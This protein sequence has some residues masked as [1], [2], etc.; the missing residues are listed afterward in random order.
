MVV[1]SRF[2]LTVVALIVLLPVCARCADFQGAESI[3]KKL[4][5][6]ESGAEQKKADPLD[7]LEAKLQSYRK[8]VTDLTPEEAASQWL[9]LLD[10]LTALPQ[11]SLFR[12]SQFT[13]SGVG[14]DALFSALPP[15]SAWD[16]LAQ[17]LEERAAKGPA[18]AEATFRLLA[19]LLKGDASAR[20]KA[21]AALRVATVNSKRPDFWG[22]QMDTTVDLLV[23]TLAELDDTGDLLAAFTQRLVAA[24]KQSKKQS[25]MSYGRSGRFVVPDIVKAA[26]REKAAPLLLRAILLPG[27]QIEIQ[28][29]ATHTL[30][31]ELALKNV[32]K[33]TSPKWELI[34]TIEDAPL[35]EAMA[36]RFPKRENGSDPSDA[37][38]VYLLSLIASGKTKEASAFITR[39]GADLRLGGLLFGHHGVGRLIGGTVGKQLAAFLHEVLLKNPSALFWDEYI[40]FSARS[41]QSAEALALLK[42]S[43]ERPD[44][45][46]EARVA[47]VKNFAKALLA[48]DQVD[49][50]VRVL[51]ET[52][53]IGAQGVKATNAD[54]EQ[55]YAK[56]G[57][58]L[59]PEA[60]R[61]I[62]RDVYSDER[63]I[64]SAL[65]LARIGQL[66]GRPEL[67]EEGITAA[68]KSFEQV[69]NEWGRESEVQSLADLLIA[70]NRGPEAEA[71]L[72]NELLRGNRDRSRLVATP[73]GRA[74]LLQKLAELYHI[75][76]RHAD[77]LKLLD[78]ATDWGAA[79][80]IELNDSYRSG[81]P[82]MHIAASA[83]AAQGRN[84]EAHK[85]TR[86]QLEKHPG[87]DRG[88]ALLLK[89]GG[90]QVDAELDELAK[91]DR[92]EE[93]PLI[94]KAQRL[95]QAGQLEDA[96]K[97][98]R[99]AIAIDPSDGEQGKGDRMRAYAVLGDILEKKGDAAQA[100]VM[101]G[102][103]AAI[104]LSED[105]DDW[106]T[107]GLLSR[108]VKKYEE[109]LGLFA[110]AYCIQSR[111]ALRYSELGDFARAEQYYRRAYE[112]MPESFGRVESHC[113]GCEGAFQG[114]RA[115]GIAETVFTRLAEK[116]PE[117]P[118]VHYLLGYLRSEQGRSEEAAASYRKAVALDPDYLNAWLKLSSLR[119]EITMP[120][121]ES[122]AIAFAILRLDPSG[123][124]GSTE[125][126][127]VH[128]LRR[129]WDTIL[130]VEKDQPPL[131]VEPIFP[132]RAN[133]AEIDRKRKQQ[134][135][136]EMFPIGLYRPREQN[137]R[138]SFAR[139][140]VIYYLA[141]LLRQT[142][143]NPLSH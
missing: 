31:G 131:S 30:A 123:R 61:Q 108:A 37:E 126:T 125:T 25:G 8:T 72:T 118:Q 106:W 86:R 93:R 65:Q 60:L 120:S 112:L 90:A 27:V 87:F 101:R 21:I 3:L 129:Y 107:A 91:R 75:N 67:I 54:L 76:G 29:K 80:L 132:L 39:P 38:L 124:H 33:L 34:Q 62:N 9:A 41:G 68:Q 13:G 140:P 50:G 4:A 64:E 130:T 122:D 111:L 115:Q 73:S 119:G 109:A 69:G 138:D 133:A 36:K 102:A 40:A 83:L 71:L 141:E 117:K 51:R 46:A 26:G 16:S 135:D 11:E 66:L 94:W 6:L 104:R 28:G 19:A 98:I 127:Q 10:A 63:S 89:I 18:A 110:D 84:E 22:E 137:L 45:S 43:A 24:E 14:V 56:L 103:V 2:P 142:L 82:M 48:A 55:R 134:N 74:E 20:G 57:I 79:D 97:S 128:D 23:Q 5:A 121:A 114:D 15:T 7:E 1:S 96:E 85:I 143:R 139:Q 77:V 92:F 17:Q 116:N 113:F 136:Q 35:Y 42:Q 81:T 88:Y 47:L 32:A 49:E 58:N 100:K 12:R 95:L 99:A 52:I 70:L 53:Q 44:L 78:E 105:A 59:P